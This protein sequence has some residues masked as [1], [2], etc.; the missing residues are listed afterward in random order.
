MK[1]YYILVITKNGPIFVTG[2]DNG[3]RMTYFDKL[4]EP[5][6]F[7]TKKL[8]DEILQGLRFNGF[9]A[10]GVEAPQGIAQPYCYDR[11]DC[12]LQKREEA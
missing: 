4:K 12:I 3:A 1:G 10:Y 2:M 6:A 8:R 5:M 9:C 11:Y 7:R